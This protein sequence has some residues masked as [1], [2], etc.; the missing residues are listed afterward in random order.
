MQKVKNAWDLHKPAG[1]DLSRDILQRVKNFRH[2]WKDTLCQSTVVKSR[3]QESQKNQKTL[4]AVHNGAVD[5][6]ATPLQTISQGPAK[7][8]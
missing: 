4:S 5:D 7:S 6:N 1:L 8:F 2:W 3:G